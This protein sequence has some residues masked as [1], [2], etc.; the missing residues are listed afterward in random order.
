MLYVT[1]DAPDGTQSI[2]IVNNQLQKAWTY[3][4]GQWTDVSSS[5]AQ[6]YNTW[7]GTWDNYKNYLS[8]LT[9]GSFTYTSGTTTYKISNI[10]VNP[11]LDDS[12]FV[13]S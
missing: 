12:L 11:Q 5:Y 4:N 3:T 8:L 10:T 2:Y 1:F 7:K 6:Q 9:G 13:H